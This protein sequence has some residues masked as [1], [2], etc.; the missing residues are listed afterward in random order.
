MPRLRR[1]V[2]PGLPHHIVQRGNRRSNIFG[3]DRDRLVFLRILKQ[4]SGIHSLTHFAYSLMT[5][6]FHLV[7]RP[8]HDAS[9]SAAMRDTL[10]PYA[11]YFNQKYGLSGR[12]W[13]GRFFSVVVDQTRF[14]EVIRY[15]ER[16][17]VR[18]GM[19]KRAEEYYWSS[20]AAHCF[21]KEDVLIQP[22][23]SI[24]SMIGSWSEWL[25]GAENDRDLRQI[26]TN[27]KTGRPYGSE[28]F[29]KALEA[30]LGRELLVRRRGRPKKEI[31]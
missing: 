20:A 25:N 26:R 16:N 17:P 2:V 18:A 24:P 12:L 22:L 15:T 1:V 6:H 21:G 31:G 27:T 8:E 10:G 9:L 23:P 5:N 28:E 29:V 13:Q 7:S 3:D 11:I 19:V 30:V 4:A 14:W